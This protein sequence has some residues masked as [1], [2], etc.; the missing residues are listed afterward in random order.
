MKLFLF[1]SKVGLLQPNLISVTIQFLKSVEKYA[2]KI[3]KKSGDKPV[4]KLVEKLAKEAT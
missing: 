4:E 1:I 3:A 2:E